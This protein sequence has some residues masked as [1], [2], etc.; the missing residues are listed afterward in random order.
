M[1][2][3][4]E[5]EVSAV[6]VEFEL[7][8]TAEP[9][10]QEAICQQYLKEHRQYQMETTYYDTPTGAL[11]QRR[12]TLRRRMEN[13]EAVCTVKTPISGYG[14]GEWDCNC[15]RIEDSLSLLCQAGAPRELMELAAEGLQSVCG[16]RFTRLAGYITL[17]GAVVELA[18]DR[19][20]LIGGGKELDL[21]EVEVELKSGDPDAAVAFG[22]LLQAR[23]G[24]IPQEKSKFRRALD[25]AQGG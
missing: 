20:V 15:E 2:L 21:C 11:S 5:R 6:G 4:I 14:R 23:Y 24:L 9:A 12:F 1:E 7:K 13:G 18:L 8:Y 17:D 16:A 3:S 19:G 22:M 10:R 25:L